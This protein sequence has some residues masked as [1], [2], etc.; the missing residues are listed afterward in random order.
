MEHSKNNNLLSPKK[1]HPIDLRC[2]Y[3]FGLTLLQLM[4]LLSTIGFILVGVYEFC[5]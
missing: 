3:K 5:L 1:N 4:L 2:Y